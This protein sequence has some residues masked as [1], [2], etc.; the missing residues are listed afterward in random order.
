MASNWT[1]GLAIAIATTLAAPAAWAADR[2]TSGTVLSRDGDDLVLDLGAD[3]GLHDGDLV[4]LWRPLKVKHPVTGKILEDRFR[5]GEL[6]LTQVRPNLALA[7]AEGSL[8]RPPAPGDVVRVVV[9]TAPPLPPP[10]PV[11]PSLPSGPAPSERPGDPEAAEL[12]ALFDELRGST[13]EARAT[14]YEAFAAARPEG[15]FAVVLREE[16]AAL[17]GLGAKGRPPPEAHASITLPT[18]AIAGRPLRLA[19]ELPR[20]IGAV[21]Y[22]RRPAELSYAAFPL[23]PVGEDYYAVTLPAEIVTGSTVYYFIESTR[24]DGSTY[25]VIGGAASPFSL[26]VV[27]PPKPAPPDRVGLSASLWTDYALWDKK[28]SLGNADDRVSQTEGQA[29]VRYGDVGV[30]A[31]RSGFGVYRGRGGTLADLDS[32]TSGRGPRSVG[33]TYGYLEAEY[34]ILPSASL[35]GRAVVGLRDDG[36]GGGAQGFVRIGNDRATNLSIGGE[37]LGGIGL[38]GIVQLEWRTLPRFPILLRT[39]VTNQPAGAAV[40]QPT[41]VSTA[42]PA[43]TGQGEVGARAI[44]QAGYRV[45]PHLELALR[46]SY[47][48]RTITHAGPGAGAAVSYEW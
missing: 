14:R 40:S 38:R 8:L 15:R 4:E 46:A 6:R 11:A 29:G 37:V 43:S 19:L 22:V 41:A 13:P 39:E 32:T 16:A 18:S 1:F 9:A 42:L 31:V 12:S 5:I 20:S 44:V 25:P 23:S 30:R 10:G 3:R 36:V 33:L 35:I 7:R 34:G 45:T 48:G 17:R 26:E 27:E 2:V 47:Q 28:P 21:L 24:P